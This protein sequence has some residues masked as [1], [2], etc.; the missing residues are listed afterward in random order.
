MG[1]LIDRQAAIDALEKWESES[2]WDEW[3]Y[4]H[5]DEAEKYSVI[6]PSSV[7]F[8]LPSALPNTQWIPCS[9][10]TMPKKTGY[11]LVQYT[12]KYCRNEMA[13]AFYSV[14]EAHC[15]DDYTWEIETF[16]DIKEVIAWRPL[17]EPYREE[18]EA[19]DSN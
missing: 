18:G 1:D 15:D 2:T 13:V 4:D 7:I 9:P 6:S 5:R 16:S 3:C 11:Y 10:E 8:G 19:D 17:P 12:R 14:K